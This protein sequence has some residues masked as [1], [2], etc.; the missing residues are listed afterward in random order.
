MRTSRHL[1]HDDYL[2][3]KNFPALDGLRAL[4]V[5]LVF[6]AHFGGLAW[7]PRAGWLG[8]HAF[9]VLS[10][11]LITTLLLRERDAT[12]GISLKAFY[13]RRG[14][15]LLPVYLL[16]FA[17]VFG[18]SWLAQGEAWTQMKAAAPYH[19]TLLNEWA[20][21][22]PFGMTWT[23]GVE[24]KYYA[25]WSLLLMLFGATNR[26]CF[27][28]A[29]G[30][31]LLL[32][33][34]WT[35]GLASK[36]LVPWH[37]TGVLLGSV[38]AIA[39]HERRSFRWLQRLASGTV[40]AVIALL[41]LLVHWRSASI[42]ARLGE[43]QMILLY[44]VLVALWLPSLIAPTFMSRGLAARALVFVGR[45]SYAL[46]LVQYIAWNTL[47]AVFPGLIVGPLALAANFMLALLIADVLY[48]W[49]EQPVMAWGHRLAAS[50]RV[51]VQG[52]G[53]LRTPGGG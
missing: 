19:L 10:G 29:A 11:F 43:A 48:R 27:A 13:I 35:G 28:T 42:S 23:L 21:F 36:W 38:L 26:A 7:A 52:L 50:A 14:T 44:G 18:L 9:F 47:L 5:V 4:S 8:V 22:S 1:A 3:Q 12:G 53:G 16:V 32:A 15:R 6:G 41:L 2:R 39:M 40:S 51:P 31:M 49:V 46:Y 25:V 34:L 30:C 24:W 37:Y 45:R 33:L 17:A 20:D